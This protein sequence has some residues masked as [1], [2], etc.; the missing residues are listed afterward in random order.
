VLQRGIGYMRINRL[1]VHQLDSLSNMLKDCKTII[2][3]ARGYPRD[4]HIGTQLAS[5]IAVKSDTVA[6]NEFPFV[7]SPDLSKNHSLVEYEVIQPAANTFFK[8]KKYYILV[9]EGIQSQAEWNVIA[10]QGVTRATTI[11]TQTAGANGMA[12]TVNF[13]GQYFSFFSGFSEYYPDGTPNQKMGV[14]IDIPVNRTLRGYL[15][16]DDEIL[17]KALSEIRKSFVK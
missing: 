16:G 2:L 10:L 8:N 12:I 14:K 1:Y 15:N 5:Y 11:G 4:G 17:Q 9:D 6:Y 3:D 13:P 7:T